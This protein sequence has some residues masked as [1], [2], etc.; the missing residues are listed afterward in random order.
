MNKE[1]VKNKIIHLRK[2]INEHNYCYYVLN[3]PIISDYEFDILLQELIEYEKNYPEFYDSFSPSQ[4]V[5]GEIT[6]NFNQIKH[7]YPMLSLGNTY[8]YEDIKDFDDR[9]KKTLFE[10]YEYV[11]ELKFDGLSVGLTYVN[12][13]LK[14]AVTRGDGEQGDDITTN[15]KT[16]KSIPL[17]LNGNDYPAEFEIRGEIFM[18]HS[19]FIRLNKER[20]ENDELPF[21]NP[22]NAASGSIKMQDSKEVANRGLDC[23]FYHI[24]G[25]NLPYSSHYENLKKAK[26]WGFKISDYIVKCSTIAHVYDFI[27]SWE[28]E[29]S[30]LPFDIDGAVIKINSYAQ[31]NIL[32]FTSK[33]PRWAIAYKFKAENV[34][35]QLISVDF[36]VGRTGAITPVANLEP[37][38]LAGTVVKRAT[39]HNADQIEKLNLHHHDFVFV[40]KGG[41]IIPKITG[42]DESKRVSDNAK[43]IMFI[44]HCPECGSILTRNEGESN[45]Y[46]SNDM[47]CPPQIKGKIEHFISRKAMNIE[48]L[49]EGKIE[50]LFNNKL[51]NNITDLYDLSYDQLLGIEKEYTLEN[52]K[53]RIVKFK[54]KTVQNILKGI[55][56]S[57]N[58]P[59]ERVL[60]AIGIRY[61]GETVAK[62]LAL[63]FKDISHLE[64]AALEDLLQVDEI[65]DKIANSIMSFFSN[66]K[67]IELIEKLKEKGL[68]FK[69]IEVEGM[70]VSNK[71]NGKSFVVSGVFSNFSREQIKTLIEKNGGKNISSLSAKTDYLLAGEK[72][73]PE[74]K[75]KAETLGIN[76]IS[77]DEFLKMIE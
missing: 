54:E 39:L 35:T 25:E 27:S 73:G 3:K 1:D 55:E 68:Q 11:C 43:K 40:E 10:D 8:S 20:E 26:L 42:V 36:Q 67:N 38:Q 30:I 50:I 65:G 18:P 12:G 19:S 47:G 52:N 59:F 7:T 6:K 77:E 9:I 17:Q 63:Y 23:F 15:I 5:G 2:I 51:I 37:V 71:L 13:K 49:G 34:S 53:K 74:K 33:S 69:M 72:M 75:K 56:E 32:G 45:H 21:A 57:K 46:C 4:R 61:V 48:S 41:D 44:S 70:I 28:K 14:H 22:R 24:I 64:E 31:Q 60:Y 76:I 29:R 66:K 16:I 58:V 62:K